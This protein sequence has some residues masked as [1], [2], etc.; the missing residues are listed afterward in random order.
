MMRRVAW[1]HHIARRART[2]LV[3]AAGVGGVG[4]VIASAPPAAVAALAAGSGQGETG[5]AGC[6]ASNPP[7]ALA[8]IAGTPQTTAL[9]TAFA[10]G[11]QVALANRDGCPVSG[12]AGIPVTFTGPSTGA[13]GTFSGSGSNTVTVGSDAAGGV[14]APTFTANDV[15]GVYTLTASSQY[16]S[17]WFSLTN[18]AVGIPARIVAL[19]PTRESAGATDRYPR[20]LRVEVLDANGDAVPGVPVTFTLDPGASGPCGAATDAGASFTVGAG[21]QASETT[22]ANGAASSP[23]FTADGTAG[24]LTATAKVSSAAGPD[25]EARAGSPAP[26]S[27]ALTNL[28]GRP[29]ELTAGIGATQSTPTGAPFPIRL[30]VIVT[31]AEKNRVPRA[32]VTFSAPAGEPSGRFTTAKRRTV[33]HTRAVEVRTNSCGIAV[34]PVFTADREQGGYIVRA[35]VA[36]TRPVAFAL[37][38]EAPGSSP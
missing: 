35:T 10:T 4:V 20:P 28:A 2:V 23:S 17:V 9:G 30:A 8:L 37:V 14:S 33:V 38:N 29:S 27:F 18:T 12:A 1:F 7:N 26:V 5:A 6:P 15:A 22:G 3:L 36:R 16:G 13:G 31:D 24:S 11:L 25:S 32:L 34:A 21:T 19:S